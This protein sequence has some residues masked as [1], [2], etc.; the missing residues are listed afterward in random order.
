VVIVFALKSNT[1]CFWNFSPISITQGRMDTVLDFAL[2]S[3]RSSPT[4]VIVYAVLAG[5]R[6]VTVKFS[7]PLGVRSSLELARKLENVRRGLEEPGI[8]VLDVGWA[9]LISNLRRRYSVYYLREDGESFERVVNGVDDL[10]FVVGDQCG[11]SKE[12]EEAL[13]GV[14]VVSLGKVPYL[15][16]YCPVIVNYLLEIRRRVTQG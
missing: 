9:E 14:P 13:R 2:E 1:A 10:A 8:E 7:K 3:I 12:D 4:P 6:E 5:C 11:L 16:W 15:S